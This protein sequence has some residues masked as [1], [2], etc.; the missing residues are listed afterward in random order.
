MTHGENDEQNNP[1]LRRLRNDDAGG[2]GYGNRHSV[3]CGFRL[4]DWHY[5]TSGSSDSHGEGQF[6][7]PGLYGDQP[8]NRLVVDGSPRG[9]YG[10]G[11]SDSACKSDQLGCQ[12]VQFIDYSNGDRSSAGNGSS[13]TAGN[14]G[15]FDADTEHG[16]IKFQLAARFSGGPDSKHVD[17]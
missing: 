11:Q 10:A 6:G 13:H 8:W 1:A 3:E 16:H 17:Q 9:R 12:N 15:T 7:N 14:P 2:Y 5:I 4:S